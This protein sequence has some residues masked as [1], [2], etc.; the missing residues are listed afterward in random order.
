VGLVSGGLGLVRRRHTLRLWRGYHAGILSGTQ[1]ATAEA[2]VQMIFT[3]H[4]Q[5]TVH[6]A[7]DVMNS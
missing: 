2:G 6:D 5:A 1:S 3:H 7:L 4:T